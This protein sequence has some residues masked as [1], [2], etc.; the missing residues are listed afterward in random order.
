R[1]QAVEIAEDRLDQIL[2]LGFVARQRARR[3]LHPLPVGGLEI[4]PRR[5]ITL[6]AGERQSELIGA[7]LREKTRPAILLIQ[8]TSAQSGGVQTVDEIGL[9]QLITLGDPG[10]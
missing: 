1:A 3:R 6:L 8:L 5:L 7:Q 4:A 10:P 9:R 2:G